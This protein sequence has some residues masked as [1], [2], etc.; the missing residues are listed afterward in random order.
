MVVGH[1]LVNILGF[2]IGF[3]ISLNLIGPKNASPVI[4][5]LLRNIYSNGSPFFGG[6]FEPWVELHLRYE[7]K[8]YLHQKPFYPFSKTKQPK[9]VLLIGPIRIMTLD[10]NTSSIQVQLGLV[11]SDNGR[12]YA[13]AYHQ[14]KL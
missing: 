5:F 11:I 10:S 8:C 13:V 1:T 6:N 7:P 12:V 2:L 9:F 14:R 3:R 4:W